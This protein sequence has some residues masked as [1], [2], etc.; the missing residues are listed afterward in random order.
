MEI[1]TFQTNKKNNSREF[2]QRARLEY[3]TF[4]GE[5]DILEEIPQDLDNSTKSDLNSRFKKYQ[6]SLPQ[7]KGGN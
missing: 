4:E 6:R 3:E 2:R 7:Y 1:S 5:F